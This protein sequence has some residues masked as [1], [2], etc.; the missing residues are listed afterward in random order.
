MQALERLDNSCVLHLTASDVPQVRL[1]VKP[2]ALSSVG[3]YAVLERVCSFGG[4]RVLGFL[5]GLTCAPI[6]LPCPL[7]RLPRVLHWF[8]GH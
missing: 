5:C 4:Q 2:D 7:R 8:V 3:G 6:P 1:V